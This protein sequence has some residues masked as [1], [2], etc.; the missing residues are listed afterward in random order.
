VSQVGRGPASPVP[1]PGYHFAAAWTMATMPARRASN[2][3]SLTLASKLLEIKFSHVHS[4]MTTLIIRRSCMG[5]NK[6][7]ACIEACTRCASRCKNLV[8]NSMHRADLADCVPA[9]EEC[10]LSCVLCLADLLDGS[11]PL[12]PAC[13]ACATACG[14]CAHEC[15]KHLVDACDHCAEACHQCAAACRELI[16]ALQESETA[17]ALAGS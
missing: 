17:C 9:C 16:A 13:L 2:T 12:I 11:S 5:S 4:F 10:F 6:L 8:A 15:A 1:L 3:N 7:Q 14:L